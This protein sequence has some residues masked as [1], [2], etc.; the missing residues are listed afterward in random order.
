MIVLDASVILKLILPHEKDRDRAIQLLD[1][2]ISGN[3]RIAAPELLYYEIANVLVTKTGLT[4]EAAYQGFERI[5]DL[6]IETFTLGLKE[7]LNAIELAARYAITAYDASYI[8][9]AKSLKC[10]LTTADEK[11]WMKTKE[12]GFVH[13]LGGS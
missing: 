8:S 5:F 12:L 6:E 2:H 7:Y 4:F 3:V 11:L 10:K 1:D 9:L 13:L